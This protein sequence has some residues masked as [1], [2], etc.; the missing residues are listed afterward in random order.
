VIF[1]LSYGSRAER[2]SR[3]HI[4]SAH[5]FDKRLEVCYPKRMINTY[6]PTIELATIFNGEC[7]EDATHTG[8]S[9]FPYYDTSNS[10]ISF[11]MAC[12]ECLEVLNAPW[13]A[14]CDDGVIIHRAKFYAW[15]Y[16]LNIYSTFKANNYNDNGVREALDYINPRFWKAEPY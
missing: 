5:S 15:T 11:H 4:Q 1:S 12:E 10:L 6:D 8:I 2:T 3:A 16:D 7:F 9:I 14:E 13:Y